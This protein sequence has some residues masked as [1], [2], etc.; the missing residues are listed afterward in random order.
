MQYIKD[1][2]KRTASSPKFK[3]R[4]GHRASVL[5]DVTPSELTQALHSWTVAKAEA[6]GE[7]QVADLNRGQHCLCYFVRT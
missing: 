7:L 4:V 5:E 3:T 2:Q 1:E 6:L